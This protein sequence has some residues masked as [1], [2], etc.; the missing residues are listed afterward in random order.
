MNSTKID[1]LF[2]SEVGHLK[3]HHLTT[4]THELPSFVSETWVKTQEHEVQG[5]TKKDRVCNYLILEWE[6]LN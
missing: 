5:R 1:L 3:Y 4:E 2:L 6:N